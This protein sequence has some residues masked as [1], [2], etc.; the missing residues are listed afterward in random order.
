MK[1]T[2][3]ILLMLSVFPFA[4]RAEEARYGKIVLPNG[5]TVISVGQEGDLA[6][7]CLFVRVKEDGEPA[8]ERGLTGVVNHTLLSCDP[9]G[10]GESAVL[11]IEQ[12]GGFITIDTGKEYTCFTLSVPSSKAGPA[13]KAFSDI[14]ISPDF[15]GTAVSREKDA[16]AASWL[17]RQDKPHEKVCSVLSC[18]GSGDYSPPDVENISAD[19]ASAWYSKNYRPTGMVLAVCG[20][21]AAGLSKSAGEA[22][23]RYLPPMPQSAEKGGGVNAAAG[24]APA[25]KDTREAFALGYP[26]PDAGSPDYP[27]M[28]VAKA[29]LA[30]GM[31]SEMFKCLRGAVAVSYLFGSAVEYGA[32]GPKLVL[33]ATLPGAENSATAAANKVQDA[34]GAVREGRVA[35]QDFERARAYA[36]GELL[37]QESSRSLARSAGLYQFLGL[38]PDYGERLTGLVGKTG[39]KDVARAAGR[40]LVSCGMAKLPM[41]ADNPDGD[42]DSAR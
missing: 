15:S 29:L 14:F 42:S 34:V 33:Y 28:L 23:G 18:G 1:K 37:M 17:R 4:A 3:L 24:K 25:D 22:F 27:A 41:A 30:S 7:A 6:S 16:S 5:L 36:E 35:Q 13:I 12:L 20:P 11:K 19:A 38:G 40:Y 26:M 32:S 2:L 39:K 21:D 8:G 9:L 10:K 31:G